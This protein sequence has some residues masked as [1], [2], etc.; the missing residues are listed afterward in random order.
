MSE[1]EKGKSIRI[2]LNVLI[3]IVSCVLI[4]CVYKLGSIW[5]EY[6]SNRQTQ[7]QVQSL[8]YGEQQI[9]EV[10]GQE[11]SI[12]ETQQYQFNLAPVILANSDTVGWITVP[13]TVIDY[14][15]VQGQDNNKYLHRGFYGEENAAGAI[16]MDAD[17]QLG[18]PLQNL[19]IYGH[20]MKD[21]SMFGELGKYLDYG[22]Y[23]QNPSFTFITEE[24]IYD[25]EIFAVYQCTTAVDYCQL[26]FATGDEQQE[27]VRACKDRSAYQTVVSVSAE[28]T[29]ITLS[30]CDYELDANEGRLVVQAKLTPKEEQ[31]N[32]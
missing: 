28:D 19:L 3:V 7:E 17:N 29:I 13:G 10:S 12:D 26:S 4:F 8:F 30:T 24:G 25:C 27:Y 11:E 23:Q 14:A 31:T 5:W 22:F 21:D 20:R 15:V 16:F 18:E 6:H 2:I 9:Q 32:E 1:K